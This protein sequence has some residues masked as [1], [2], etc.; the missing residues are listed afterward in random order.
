MFFCLE[1]EGSNGSLFS[2]IGRAH[3]WTPVTCQTLVCRL[4][5]EKKNYYTAILMYIKLI[6][7]LSI[8]LGQIYQKHV[9]PW[10]QLAVTWIPAYCSLVK[11]VWGFSSDD[12]VD[13]TSSEESV[14]CTPVSITQ[15]SHDKQSNQPDLSAASC[16]K[17][18]T[19]H[20]NNQQSI[21]QSNHQSNQ[22][23]IQ[24]RVD[25]ES[26]IESFI[27]SN[28]PAA[29]FDNAKQVASTEVTLALFFKAH[30]SLEFSFCNLLSFFLSIC[31]RGVSTRAVLTPTS[32]VPA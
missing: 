2:K 17:S 29:N 25:P 10:E 22:Q 23:S 5:L 21:Q 28:H 14:C 16:Y 13:S 26:L 24:Q 20:Q 3:V 27:P 19:N 8:P 7:V 4:L 18:P 31:L 6:E 1:S 32:L 12:E 15:H 9:W 11:D 30:F